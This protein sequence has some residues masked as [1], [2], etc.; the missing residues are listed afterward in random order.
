[1]MNLTLGF[2]TC[3]ND[4]FM[5]DALV[6]R[7]IDTGNYAFDVQMADIFHLN[8]MAE[9]GER[10]ILKISYQTYGRIQDRYHLLDAGSALGHNCGPLL[11]SR[12]PISPAQLRV[13]TLRVAIPGANTTANLL[14]SFFAPQLTNKVEL[15]FH[16]IMP[17]LVSGEVDLGVIIHENRF[18]YQ[19]H[20]LRL[21]QDLGEY[22]EV[23]TQ[24]PIPLGAI[25]AKKSLGEAVI[26]DIERMMRE[27]VS[28]AFEHPTA[29]QPYV[30]AHAQEMDPEVMKAHIDLYVN[31]Y[32]LSLGE[33]GRKAV[34]KLLITGEKLGF[35]PQT[36]AHGVNYE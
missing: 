23:Q 5:F 7:R 30:R 15:I 31:E 2:S 26:A 3:P 4:T 8:Q 6:H 29:S 16:D 13:G 12:E 34:D 17:A 24:L 19:Q 27:S 10:D 33:K 9:A 1:M 36:P 32:S 18:T 21:V 22:W 14:L 11:I 28:Y 25:V 20:G 35:Y